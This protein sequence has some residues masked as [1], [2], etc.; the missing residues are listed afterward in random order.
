MSD[1]PCW[2]DGHAERAAKRRLGGNPSYAS[3]TCQTRAYRARRSIA[4]YRLVRPSSNPK[5][6][7]P[8]RHRKRC[9]V[10]HAVLTPWRKACAVVRLPRCQKAHSSRTW[11]SRPSS[12]VYAKG[13]ANRRKR[14]RT[15]LGWPAAPSRGLSWA[16]HRPHGPQFETS[17]WR[18]TSALGS[19]RPWSRRSNANAGS[20][21]LPRKQRTAG[22][23]AACLLREIGELT[24]DERRAWERLLEARYELLAAEEELVAATHRAS[25]RARLRVIDGGAR[26]ATEP[27][28]NAVRKPFGCG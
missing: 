26:R 15:A 6:R 3:S 18:W 23:G 11:L 2:R 27:A 25:R 4:G 7:P 12:G 21:T 24:P 28:A 14:L 22:Y 13:E 5:C 9:S 8:R 16:R 20:E 19:L 17:P 10:K 1:G